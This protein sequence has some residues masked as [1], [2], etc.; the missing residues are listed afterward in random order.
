NSPRPFRAVPFLS[1]LFNVSLEPLELYIHQYAGIDGVTINRKEY[2]LSLYADN[3]LVLLKNPHSSVLSLLNIVKAMS[4]AIN[5]NSWPVTYYSQFKHFPF[6][7]CKKI[8]Y[9]HI[10]ICPNLPNFVSINMGY[11]FKEISM[12]IGSWHLLSLSLLGR[13]E[14]AKMNICSILTY[15]ISLLPFHTPIMQFLRDI[16]HPCLSHETLKKS[17]ATGSMRLPELYLYYLV[18]QMCP[19]VRWFPSSC[20]VYVLAWFDTGGKKQTKKTLAMPFFYISQKATHTLKE[21]SRD[22]SSFAIPASLGM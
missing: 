18:F 13:R 6:Q 10:N 17:W 5:K 1:L 22:F 3:F 21:K 7:I 8:T 9:V 14:I 16:K 19:F 2:K 11:I 15:I 4:Q 20:S 12:D